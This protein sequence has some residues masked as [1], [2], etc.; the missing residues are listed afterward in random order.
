M[1]LKSLHSVNW[2]GVLQGG[3]IAP[4]TNL[5]WLAMGTGATGS[6]IATQTGGGAPDRPAALPAVWA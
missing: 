3:E 5:I 6:G 2:D 4:C 1:S